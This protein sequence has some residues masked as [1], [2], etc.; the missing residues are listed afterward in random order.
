M[1][2]KLPGLLPACNDSHLGRSDDVLAMDARGYMR[3]AF[4]QYHEQ[5]EG[6]GS[7][8][9]KLAGRDFYDFDDV[10]HWMPLP[11]QPQIDHRATKV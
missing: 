4:V 9:W 8:K 3:V 1:W 2:N 6:G 10:T 11:K 5:V 7:Y